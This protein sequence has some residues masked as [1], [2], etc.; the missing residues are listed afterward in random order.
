[1]HNPGDASQCAALPCGRTRV[2]AVHLQVSLD[3]TLKADF[4]VALSGDAP[5][6]V[7]YG[8]RPDDPVKSGPDPLTS[9]TITLTAGQRVA[10]VCTRTDGSQEG[11]LTCAWPGR[12]HSKG[13]LA[14]VRVSIQGQTGQSTGFLEKQLPLVSCCAYTM[15]SQSQR[16]WTVSGALH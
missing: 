10:I 9:P 14:L 7:T 5:T 13:A 4:G 2:T 1:M 8:R 12:F 6:G 11:V 15:H 3:T 16:A